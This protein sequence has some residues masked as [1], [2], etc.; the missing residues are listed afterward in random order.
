MK[1]K[2]SISIL[3]LLASS[4]LYGQNI[5][6]ERLQGAWIGNIILPNNS[7]ILIVMN[8]DVKGN[9]IEGNFDLPDQ[10]VKDIYIDSTWVSQ[11]SVFAAL[12][13]TVGPGAIYKGLLIPGEN[14]SR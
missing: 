8:F 5:K 9:L 7:S 13:S 6:P 1:I 12:S 2:T 4:L 11:D 3:L 10:S 14:Q